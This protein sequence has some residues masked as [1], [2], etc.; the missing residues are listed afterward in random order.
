MF[1]VRRACEAAVS[2]H[3]AADDLV[4]TAS[5]SD[6]EGYRDALMRLLDAF[7]Q[8]ATAD[9]DPCA[10][11]EGELLR[12]HLRKHMPTAEQLREWAN[13]AQATEPEN[14]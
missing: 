2:A 4:V 7:C 13:K 1:D 3:R 12:E 10:A 6:M 5:V 8:A 9:P 14:R 11:Q